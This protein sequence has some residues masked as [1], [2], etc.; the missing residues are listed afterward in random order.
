[1]PQNQ[2]LGRG[3]YSLNSQSLRK[4][5]T[6]EHGFVSIATMLIGL[7]SIG[8]ILLYLLFSGAEEEEKEE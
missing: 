8:L 2:V 7:A 6:L 5:I 4:C 3:N 1:M